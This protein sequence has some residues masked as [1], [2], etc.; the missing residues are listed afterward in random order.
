MPIVSVIVPVYNVSEYLQEGLDSILN[1]NVKD[2]E[3][4][5]VDDCSTDASLDILKEFSARD[6]RV[7]VFF[8]KTN[9]GVSYTRNYGLAK[10]TGVYVHFFDPD[11]K[12]KKNMYSEM[13]TKEADVIVSNYEC[14][15]QDTPSVIPLIKEGMYNSEE[16]IKLL[17]DRINS[18]G[19]LCYSWRCLFRLTFLRDKMLHFCEEISMGEDTVF[20]LEVFMCAQSIRIL[21]APLYVYRIN[22][23]GAA[24]KLY[25]P[26]LEQSL[27]RQ[28]SEKK[29]IS[30][31]YHLDDY[32][33]FTKD[34]S[35]DIVKRYTMMLFNNIRNNPNRENLCKGVKRVLNMQMVRDAM[36]VVGY[37]NIYS[38]W[39]EYVFYLCMKFRFVA[40]VSR[41]L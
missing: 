37:R 38:N 34:M 33:S 14:F 31:A 26:H 36:D 13:L 7:K 4:I 3:I 39:K 25:K 32:V 6:D 21:Q 15:P 17:G 9:R 12:V 10:A 19:L 18:D 35:E 8:N 5:C 22:S 27:Q 16:Y 29:R 30:V 41:M 24:R 20:N 28:I 2:I 11:D 40:I 1:Q 23:M